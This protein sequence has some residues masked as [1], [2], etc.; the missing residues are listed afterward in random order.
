M[1]WLA[2]FLNAETLGVLI[3]ICAIVGAFILAG[4]R[5]HHKHLE[6]MEKIKRGYDIDS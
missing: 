3:P 5:A 4:L 6:R 2:N 1:D